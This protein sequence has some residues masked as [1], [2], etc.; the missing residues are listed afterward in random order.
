M[1][2]SR[3]GRWQPATQPSHIIPDRIS[4]AAESPNYVV[5]SYAGNVSTVLGDIDHLNP[6][7]NDIS[8]YMMII[9]RSEICVTKCTF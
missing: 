7:L 2:G 9:E 4:S 6:I 5:L 8:T 3:N 1:R